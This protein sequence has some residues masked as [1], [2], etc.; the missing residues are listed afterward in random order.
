[1]KRWS[2]LQ[3]DIYKLIDPKINFQIQCRAYRMD[4]QR[5]SADLPRYWIT[6]DKDIIW[7]FPRDF[8]YSQGVDGRNTVKDLYPYQTDVSDISI[9]LRTYIDTPV[10]D[11]P[12]GDKWKLTPILRAADRRVG[13]RR[14]LIMN[15][16]DKK[17]IAAHK[18]IESRLKTYMRVDSHK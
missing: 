2:Q 18:I 7:D 8:L 1:L 5:G 12:P 3:R 4:S 9:F 6:L 14:L 13:K 11:K 16:R 15:K 10:S 17:N